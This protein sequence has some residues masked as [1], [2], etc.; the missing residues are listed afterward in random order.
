MHASVDS[1]L[2]TIMNTKTR[3]GMIPARSDG[4]DYDRDGFLD[5]YTHQKM[6]TIRGNWNGDPAAAVMVT[7][8]PNWADIAFHGD[9]VMLR[10]THAP[11]LV[12]QWNSNFNFIWNNHSQPA[13]Y[14]GWRSGARSMD[15]TLIP[16]DPLPGGEHWEND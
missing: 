16:S 10:T 11:R 6:F 1:E 2:R 12:R 9:E 5:M 8:S 14:R 4:F 3:R 7:G 15:G 13:P